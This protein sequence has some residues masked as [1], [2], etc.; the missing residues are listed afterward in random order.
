MAKII[1]QKWGY[2]YFGSCKST[3]KKNM[4]KRKI[5]E[6]QKDVEHPCWMDNA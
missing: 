2:P 6:D 1:S 3:I 4:S 5:G